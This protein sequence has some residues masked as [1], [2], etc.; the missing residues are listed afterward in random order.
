MI[1]RIA[2][3][4]GTV[5]LVVVGAAMFA[6]FESH[7]INVRAHVEKATYVQPD[8]IN[9]GNTLMQQSYSNQCRVAGPGTDGVFG[10]VDD[11]VE[12]VTGINC[13]RIR[14]SAS[15]LEQTEFSTVGYK[16]YC[17]AKSA[18]DQALYAID[19]GI[20]EY[21]RLTDSDGGSDGDSITAI[22]CVHGDAAGSVGPAGAPTT[23]WAQGSLVAGNDEYDLWD[24]D[25]YAPV[26]ENNWNEFTDPGSPPPDP[27]SQTIPQEY[28]NPGPGGDS[29]EY[30]NLGSN[31]KFQVTEFEE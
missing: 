26:C 19:H 3:L 25:F 22:N 31:V 2:L 6:A 20:T 13:L 21:M 1:K 14:L 11:N 30:T 18:E 12:I 29:D 8:D 16:V 28:C 7:V 15:F 5:V 10:T 17:E 23:S 9:L 4:L 27:I 24:F